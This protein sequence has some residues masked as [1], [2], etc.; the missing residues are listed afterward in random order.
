[1]PAT[2]NIGGLVLPSARLSAT[3]GCSPNGL[4]INHGCGSTHPELLQKTVVAVEAAVGIALDGDG[5]RVV[6]VDENGE[7]ID[8]D[9]LLYILAKARKEEGKLKGPV[10]GTVMSNLGLKV[11]CRKYGLSFHA[12]PVGDRYVIEDMQRLGGIIGGAAI[13]LALYFINF[14]SL[15]FFFPWFFSNWF[16]S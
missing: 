6:M 5:D 11:A 7:I 15:T 9:Q 3:I 14:Y 13:G 16:W 2:M 4:N 8:G 12:S 1:M 10:V